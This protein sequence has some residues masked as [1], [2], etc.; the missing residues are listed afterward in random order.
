MW[1]AAQDA[2]HISSAQ[3]QADVERQR[4]LSQAGGG[5]QRR[6]HPIKEIEAQIQQFKAWTQSMRGEQ[7][8]EVELK[9]MVGGMLSCGNHKPPQRRRGEHSRR[10]GSVSAQHSLPHRLLSELTVQVGAGRQ[11]GQAVAP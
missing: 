6:R 8:N 1:Q 11:V 2:I 4:K 3:G 7:G 10:A 5:S 9:G